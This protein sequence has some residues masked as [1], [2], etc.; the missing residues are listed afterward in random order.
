MRTADLL[1]RVDE[2]RRWRGLSEEELA[3]RAGIPYR[4]F[5]KFKSDGERA[6]ITMDHVF[7]L[8]LTLKVSPVALFKP[9]KAMRAVRV[10]EKS[11]QTSL[12]RSPSD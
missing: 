8:S 7:S 12:P 11:R 9:P 5:M 10:K 2:L 6:R 3:E 4:K 1:A